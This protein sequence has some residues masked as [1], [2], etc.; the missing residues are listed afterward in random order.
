VPTI[1]KS[2]SIDLA[3]QIADDVVIGPYCNIEGAVTIGAGSRL[4]GQ[5]WLRGPLTIG[6]ENIFYPNVCIGFEPQHRKY[7][8]GTGAGVFIGDNNVLREGA[9]IHGSTGDL[10]TRL[11]NNNFLMTNSHLGHDAAVADRCTLASGAM[12]GGHVIV[13]DEAFIGGLVGVHQFCRIGR[14]AILGGG[15]VSTRDVLPFC[16]VHYSKEIGSLNIIGLRRAGYRQHIP[17]LTR[18]IR[19]LYESRH[20]ISNALRLIEQELGSD[21]LCLELVT[22]ARAT[23]RGLSNYKKTEDSD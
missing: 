7:V 18:A 16:T 11:G 4:I 13:E 15:T 12:L 23:K 3:A 2:S 10:P 8:P 22:F 9:T 5:V 19:I 17:N 14:L 20:S 1:H 21:P 6:R